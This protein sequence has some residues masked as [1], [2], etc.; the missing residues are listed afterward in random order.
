[1]GFCN[2]LNID[3]LTDSKGRKMNKGILTLATLPLAF[4]ALATPAE[5]AYTVGDTTYLNCET[6]SSEQDYLDFI[7]REHEKYPETLR[8]VVAHK[9][10]AVKQQSIENNLLTVEVSSSEEESNDWLDWFYS[11]IKKEEQNQSA[12]F[13]PVESSQSD[14]ARLNAFIQEAA[15]AEFPLIFGEV[16][17]SVPEMDLLFVINSFNELTSDLE[18]ALDQREI[19]PFY[20][21]DKP[22]SVR[23]DIADN[24]LVYLV[25]LESQNAEAVWKQFISIENTTD[26]QLSSVDR[27]F[28]F[29]DFVTQE[30][31]E[32]VVCL[33]RIDETTGSEANL[34]CRRKTGET[35]LKNFPVIYRPQ[36]LFDPDPCSIFELECDDDDDGIDFQFF[37]G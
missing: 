15:N 23:L 20:F 36:D 13:T 29:P 34:F 33:S 26:I 7:E 1:M 24:Y 3:H 12:T 5:A 14:I 21:T 22:L 4:L 6:C 2:R 9:G 31:L 18:I 37:P 8:Y 19:N 11:W 10:Q 28:P 35:E 30:G 27:L 32:E 17:F 16:K 25:K